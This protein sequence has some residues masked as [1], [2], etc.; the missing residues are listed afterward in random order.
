MMMLPVKER[1]WVQSRLNKSEVI[2]WAEKVPLNKVVIIIFKILFSLLWISFFIY[3]VTYDPFIHLF[4][5]FLLVVVATFALN[6][7]LEKQSVL[8][9][10]TNYRVIVLSKGNV[11]NGK[12]RCYYPNQLESYEVKKNKNGSANIL[13]KMAGSSDGDKKTANN[14]F[15]N[16]RSVANVE[17]VLGRL[18]SS[19]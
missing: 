12:F 18:M 16:I 5:F 14:S 19:Q 1:R 9:V 2:V 13:F 15:I 3:I 11:A 4:L 8:Y 7:R 6:D 10:V 17:E